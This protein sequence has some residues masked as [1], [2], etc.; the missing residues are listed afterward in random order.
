MQAILDKFNTMQMMQQQAANNA[1]AMHHNDLINKIGKPQS[2]SIKDP[3]ILSSEDSIQQRR[4]L[5]E[6]LEREFGIDYNKRYNR[7]DYTPDQFMNPMLRQGFNPYPGF[8]RSYGRD[9]S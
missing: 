3:S 4:R 7:G 5:R 2:L 8:G 9:N 6:N 1:E